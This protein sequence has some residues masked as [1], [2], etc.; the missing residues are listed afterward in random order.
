M[1]SDQANFSRYTSGYD[2]TAKFLHWLVVL[3][4]AA[5]FVIGWT[6]PGIHK[7]TRPD[8]LI[9]WHLGVGAALIA[10]V[11]VRIVWRLTHRPAPASLSPFLSVVSHVTHG[12]LYLALLAVPLLGWANASSRGWSVKLLGV[13]PYP[14]ISGV[15]SPVGHAMGD[16]HGYLAWVLFAL[17][18]LHIAAALFHR[19]VLKDQTLQRMLP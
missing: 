5:Q 4:L 2:G 16:I 10:A 19:F 7:G 8:G 3:L 14:S 12:L 18:A 17:I 6:M 13:L 11:V 15:G 1:R 9:A